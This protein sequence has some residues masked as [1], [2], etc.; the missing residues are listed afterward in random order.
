MTYEELMK[1]D[2]VSI[3]EIDMSAVP[4]LKGFTMQAL[5]ELIK[6]L[7]L[8]KKKPASLPK[9]LD[10][11]TPALVIYSIK[12][13]WQTASRNFGRVCGDIIK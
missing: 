8:Q 6:I 3:S 9:S 7:K 12:A 1:S 11:T 4:S 5:S 2:D 13:M 10:T